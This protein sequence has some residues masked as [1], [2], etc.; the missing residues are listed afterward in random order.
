L[1]P[2]ASES[3]AQRNLASVP[4]ASESVAVAAAIVRVGSPYDP[5]CVEFASPRSVLAPALS[6]ARNIAQATK[7][8]RIAERCRVGASVGRSCCAPH[9]G[10][11]TSCSVH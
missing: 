6:G 11:S 2:V 5:A 1:R 10:T 3:A 9:I 7:V 4:V 8:S